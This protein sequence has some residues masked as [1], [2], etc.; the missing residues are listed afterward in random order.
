MQQY[1]SFCDDHAK[2]KRQIKAKC[3]QAGM[4]GVTGTGVCSKKYRDSFLDALPTR[5]RRGRMKR[6]YARLDEAGRLREES[7][8]AMVELDRCYPEIKKFQCVPG[9]GVLRSHVFSAFIQTPDRFA[10]KQK[11]WSYCRL[12]ILERSSAGKPLAYKRLNHLGSG[13]LQ[14]MSYQCWQ[15]ALRTKEPNEDSLFYKASLERTGNKVHARLNTQRK[16]LTVLWTI[17]KNGVDYNPRLL[18]SSPTSAVI[19]QAAATP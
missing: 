3:Q 10:T 15:S 12:W 13:T 18:Y 1:L 14:A 8:A 6:L 2:L 17:W 5:A 16:V 9:I 11:L 19:T 4:V 7:H